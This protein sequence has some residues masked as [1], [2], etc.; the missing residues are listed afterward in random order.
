[1]TVGYRYP[2]INTPLTGRNAD[3]VTVTVGDGVE[4]A[5]FMTRPEYQI[6]ISARKI[7]LS[8]MRY[9]YPYSGYVVSTAPAA[10]NGFVFTLPSDS[11]VVFTGASLGSG[12][13]DAVNVGNSRITVAPKQLTLNVSNTGYSESTVIDIDVFTAASN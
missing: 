10:F 12:T 9:P 5:S 1:M 6:D 7:T 3:P 11:P 8:N 4:L 2:D 13:R